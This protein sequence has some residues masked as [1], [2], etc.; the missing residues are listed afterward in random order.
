[1]MGL[2]HPVGQSKL[3]NLGILQHIKFSQGKF[4]SHC[5]GGTSDNFKPQNLVLQ[6]KHI[7]GQF[8]E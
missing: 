1:M 8:L 3:P 6:K 5:D 2:G 7:L 4:Y